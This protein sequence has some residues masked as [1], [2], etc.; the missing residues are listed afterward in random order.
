MTVRP[1]TAYGGSWSNSNRFL[2]PQST[3]PWSRSRTTR[4]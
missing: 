1:L 2:A 4:F 3:Q